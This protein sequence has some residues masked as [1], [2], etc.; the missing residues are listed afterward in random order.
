MPISAAPRLVSGSPPPAGRYDADIIILTMGRL[1]ETL[2]AVAS[3]SRQ[4]SAHVYIALL[5]QGTDS[6]A[7]ARYAEVFAGCKCAG[8]FVSDTNL[9]VGG[10]RNFLSGIGH[11]DIIVALDND[12]VFADPFIVFDALRIFEYAPR[13]AAIALRIMDATGKNLDRGS[14]GF[15]ESLKPR[16]RGK[17]LT[18]TFVGAGHAIRRAAWRD[19]GGYDESLFFTWEEYD[20]SLRAIARGWHIEYRGELAVHHKSSAESRLRWRAGRT[21]LQVRNRLIIARKWGASWPSLL[22]RIAAY[23]LKGVLNGTPL[24]PLAGT[25]AA[26]WRDSRTPKQDMPAPMA[27]YLAEHD[28]AH[29]GKLLDRMGPEIFTRLAKD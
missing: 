20:F 14:W 4:A 19:A 2:E 10:G 29:R 16:A 24:A 22:P 12:A 7:R 5:D 8:F 13:L 15:P 27:R 9:G 1:A 17:F 28:Q 26:L 3:A 21:K 23:A 18:T 25:A 11:G 6:I